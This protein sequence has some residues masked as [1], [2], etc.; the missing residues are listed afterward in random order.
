[1]NSTQESCM[2]QKAGDDCDDDEDGERGERSLASHSE[3]E[4]DR[5]VECT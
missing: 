2:L 4:R 1:M 3:K 5:P